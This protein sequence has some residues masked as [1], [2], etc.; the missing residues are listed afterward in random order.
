MSDKDLSIDEIIKR[1]EE[2]KK[3]A[4][5]QLEEAEKSLNQKAKIAIDEVTVDPK[6]VLEKIDSITQEE[7]DIKEFSPKETKKDKTQTIKFPKRKTN[8]GTKAFPKI[9]KDFVKIDDEDDDVKTFNL[10]DDEDIKI[11]NFDKNDDDMKIVGE[12]EDIFDKDIFIDEKTKPVVISTNKN[13]ESPDDLHE[14]PTLIARENLGSFLHADDENDIDS[15]A[16][17]QISFDGFNTDDGKVDTIDEDEAERILEKQ[18][19]E[20]INKFR[21][22]GPEKTDEALNGDTYE[23]ED[24]GNEK[25][26]SSLLANLFNKKA[27]LQVRIGIT[28]AIGAIMLLMDIFKDSAFFPGLLSS[29]VSFTMLSIMLLVILIIA[30]FNIAIHGLKIKKGINCDFPV[31]I[32]GIIVLVH[33]IMLELIPEL[34]INNGT[35]FGP[36]LAF[37]ILLSQ[38][39]KK[40]MMSRIID[41][42]DFIITSD[43]TYTIENIANKV[44][45]SI[46]SRGIL[47]DDDPLIK[48]S[49][50]T[51]IPT[52]FM[53]ISCKNE[54]SDKLCSILTPIML[55]LSLVLTVVVGIMD[56][57]LTGINMGICAFAV[58]TP[59]GIMFLINSFLYDM[60]AQLDKF[61][62]RV[63]G[64]EGALMA[65]NTNA[66]VM[67]AGSLFG[68]TGC[69]LHGIK[70]FNQAKL[71]EAII[72]AAAV[73]THTKG[74]LAH[75]FDDV[76]IGKQ[77]IL[78]KVEKVIYEDKMGT[79]AWVYQRKVL[80]GNRNLLIN[81]GV[82]VPKES[83]ERKYTVRGRK[84]V[85]L[86]VNGNI[87]AMF[88]VSYSA[89]PELKRELRK[90]ESTGI[91]LIVKSSDPY[92]NEESLANLF[93]LPKGYIR[94]MNHPA[95]RVFDKYSDMNVESSPAYM[96]HNGSAKG[97]IS[98]MRG[99]GAIISAK[100]TIEFLVAFGCA[101][102]FA[103][104]SIFSLIKGYSQLTCLSVLGFQGIWTVFVLLISKMKRMIF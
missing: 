66:I 14:A 40:K 6:A 87:I 83:F 32:L 62:S 84:A 4:E 81:H 67:E 52:N 104:V 75:A 47:D 29:N 95:A 78:P 93:N 103:A 74:P 72:Y 64:Y 2:I 69:D 101:L 35:F 58:S 8:S 45:V 79:S 7:S 98:G 76:I 43:E 44:D 59:I 49:V 23:G 38:L 100:K 1:A 91:T 46:I 41:N 34:W 28:I 68:K 36:I 94:V 9:K 55:V 71:D 88:I 13:L 17:I 53:E 80:V 31:T 102:G 37:G 51:D 57:F 25:D 96:V 73:I 48:T 63:C 12:N 89:D 56:N 82:Q 26:K 85:Y 15:E 60:S 11:A 65:N 20:K 16:G 39:G 21:V 3:Q 42:F 27:L 24:Y 77:S 70:M 18:R 92:I 61:G 5:I 19:Q 97:F 86:A 50:K 90:L 54:P 30:N 33:T 99:A 22:F 10:G